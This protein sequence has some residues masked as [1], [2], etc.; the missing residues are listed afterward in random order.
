MSRHGPWAVL[1]IDPT[2]DRSEIKRAYARRLKITHPEDDAKGFE[3]LR[4]AYEHALRLAQWGEQR[5]QFEAQQAAAG[6]P[7]NDDDD[8]EDYGGAE[9]ITFEIAHG[10]DLSPVRPGSARPATP[11]EIAA[12]PEPQ[13]E[14]ERKPRAGTRP[15]T[16]AEREAA[17]PEPETQP[18]P[19]PKPRV[20][21]VA[22]AEMDLSEPP[23]ELKEIHEAEQRHVALIQTL[24][25]LVADETATNEARGAA[26]E[27]VLTSPAMDMVIVNE[28]TEHFLGGLIANNPRRTDDMVDRVINYFG[29]DAA[30]VGAWRPIAAAALRRRE[31][32]VE[33]RYLR[34]PGT[35]SNAAFQ[36]LNKPPTLWRKIMNRLALTREREVRNFL[37]NIR[38]RF[39]GLVDELNPQAVAWWETHFA[40]PRIGPA[41]LWAALVGAGIGLLALLNLLVGSPNGAADLANTALLFAGAAAILI[42]KH[43]AIDRARELLSKRFD[44]NYPPWVRYGWLPAALLPLIAAAFIPA[45]LPATIAAGALA[46]LPLLWALIVADPDREPEEGGDWSSWSYMSLFTIPFWLTQ[47]AWRPNMRYPWQARAV[48]GF[49][50]VAVFYAVILQDMEPARWGQMLA[51]LAAACLAVSLG[52]GT[53][54]EAWRHETDRRRRTWIAGGAIGCGLIGFVLSLVG[55]ASVFGPAAIVALLVPVLVAK[56]PVK[57][58][59][60]GVR[61]FRDAITRY[62]W[63]L[64]LIYGSLVIGGGSVGSPVF[65]VAVP[66]LLTGPLTVLATG[67]W[68]EWVPQQPKA[69]KAPK[70]KRPVWDR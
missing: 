31:E 51:P 44:W 36:A 56:A 11:E 37:W 29:W 26:L 28:R 32:V 24:V 16:E 23:P 62:G 9:D 22:A 50:F 5:R 58:A 60:E 12:Q 52:L 45:S 2:E 15:A 21:V 10:V 70:A 46:A 33:L 25:D 14:P 19:P 39:P 27:A 20:R 8:V 65:L 68:K 63:M 53:L 34:A 30:R 55:P 69:P 61:M 3:Q 7:V 18:V 54:I 42:G 64:W 43:Y 41:A 66:W 13:A 38:E 40:Q 59:S 49:G 47:W 17:G 1:E 35:K 6:V 67:L 4:A 57:D 48:F